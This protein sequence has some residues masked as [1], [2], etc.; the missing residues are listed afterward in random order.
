MKA[1]I[2]IW[3]RVTFTFYM[4]VLI[5]NTWYDVMLHNEIQNLPQKVAI[6]HLARVFRVFTVYDAH[7]F[8]SIERTEITT[9]KLKHVNTGELSKN[10]IKLN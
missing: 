10:P 2:Y 9:I 3:M 6:C 4:F 1:T 5:V 8:I 7:T